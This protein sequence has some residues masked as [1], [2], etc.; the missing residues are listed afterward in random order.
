[1]AAL[2]AGSRPSAAISGPFRP[3]TKHLA[4][5]SSS[6]YCGGLDVEDELSPVATANAPRTNSFYKMQLS[7]QNAGCMINKRTVLLRH[8]I[9]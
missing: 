2:S 5:P 7:G 6:A 8:L 3:F 4:L 9:H 1:M